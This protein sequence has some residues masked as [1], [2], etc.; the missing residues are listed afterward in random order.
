MRRRAFTLIELLAAMIL[1]AV[2]A[3]I[4]G[5]LFQATFR[6]A[7]TS[8]QTQE[9]MATFDVAVATMRRD[10]WSAQSVRAEGNALMIGESVA[11][12]I[13][14]NDLS[15]VEADRTSHWPIP[16]NATFRADGPAIVLAV[17]ESKTAQAGDVRMISQM[18]LLN[19]LTKK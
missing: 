12:K 19:E 11:W 9:A 13:S 18:Q 6:L 1:L 16:S 14:G 2:F 5:R 3:L 4:A 15:R 7:Q 17:P 8:T 10:V